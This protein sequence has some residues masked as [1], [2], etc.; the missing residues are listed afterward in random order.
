VP[1]DFYN[2]KRLTVNLVILPQPS[3]LLIAMPPFWLAVAGLFFAASVGAQ[4]V[5]GPTTFGPTSGGSSITVTGSWDPVSWTPVV[6]LQGI[7]ISA[8][9]WFMTTTSLSIKVPPGPGKSLF[10]DVNSSCSSNCSS[11]NDGV[12]QRLYT[13]VFSYNPPIIS[14]VL[15]ESAAFGGASMTIFGHNFGKALPDGTAPN[16]TVSACFVAS[17][18]FV[19]IASFIAIQ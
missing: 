17:R 7:V 14:A 13:N 4:Y 10:L 5:V 18:D 6:A 8:T 9:D 1:V 3:T 15:P 11:G 19:F 12:R 2:L 16:V